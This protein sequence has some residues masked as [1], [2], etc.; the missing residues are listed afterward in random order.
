MSSKKHH[1]HAYNEKAKLASNPQLFLSY[2]RDEVREQTTGPKYEERNAS[3]WREETQT[4]KT[5]IK[6]SNTDI[7]EIL[8]RRRERE[9]A[10]R[11]I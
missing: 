2:Q 10:R 8:R 11:N 3:T 7:V 4:S 6:R 9:W 1:S 5:N